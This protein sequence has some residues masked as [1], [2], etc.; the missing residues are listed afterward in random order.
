MPRIRMIDAT[1]RPYMIDSSDPE[2]LA[3]WLW[4]T[5]PR[6]G[7][8]HIYPSS[9]R[10]EPLFNADG[11]PDWPPNASLSFVGELGGNRPVDNV[12]GLIAA[13]TR[14]AEMVEERS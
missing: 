7:P 12:R 3:K 8:T 5:L 13:L 6:V 1:G 14:Y 9:I 10:V 2:I 11:S 4:E